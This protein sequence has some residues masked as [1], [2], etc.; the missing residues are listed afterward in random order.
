MPSLG[1]T[2]VKHVMWGLLQH[3]NYN[4]ELTH[5]RQHRPPILSCGMGCTKHGMGLIAL[6]VAE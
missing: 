2:S 5:T 6:K 4:N 1:T 3:S